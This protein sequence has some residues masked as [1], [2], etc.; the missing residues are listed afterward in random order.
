LV[1]LIAQVNP[2]NALCDDFQSTC[3]FNRTVDM[4]PHQTNARK[5]DSV[6]RTPH[7][8]ANFA[9]SPKQP[10]DPLTHIGR[11]PYVRLS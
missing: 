8:K 7:Q 11:F 6:H 5:F 2:L 1:D 4:V 10:H 9:T 3:G